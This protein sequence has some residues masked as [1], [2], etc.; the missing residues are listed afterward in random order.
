PV[1]ADVG[2]PGTHSWGYWE[3]DLRKSWPV[4]ARSMGVEN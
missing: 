1:T 3:Q 4:L 2:A